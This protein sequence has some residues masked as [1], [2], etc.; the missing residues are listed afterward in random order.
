[1]GICDSIEVNDT[2]LGGVNKG[3]TKND[4]AH[5]KG[6]ITTKDGA[7]REGIFKNKKLNDKKI[8]IL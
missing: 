4:K 3:E 5:N 2:N 8:F 6:K 1:M 7:I